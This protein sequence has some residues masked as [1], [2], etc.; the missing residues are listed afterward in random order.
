[1]LWRAVGASVIGASHVASEVRCQDHHAYA[2]VQRAGGDALLI[3]VADGAGS[4]AASFHGAKTA[5]DEA[6]RFLGEALDPLGAGVIAGCFAAARARVL[7]VAAEGDRDPREYASTL[8][9]VAATADGTLAGQI[10]D[11][12]VVIDDGE[13]RALTWPQQGEY[14]NSTHFLVDDDALDRVALAE[15]GPAQRIAAFT[16]GLQSLALQFETRTP[17]EP[18][19][20]PFFAY[21][22]TTPKADGEIERELR[23][24]LESEPVNART[25]DDK[26][27][28]L[29]VR[30]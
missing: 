9:V 6:L 11:G 15:A 27:L 4:A 25:D 30:R 14:A 12:A 29:A 21:L 2:L 7:D 24:Y 20:A 3:A 17:F 22:E 18:F 26:S 13:L 1:V 19:F 16:D 28:V 23:A 10:G 8:L 5:V